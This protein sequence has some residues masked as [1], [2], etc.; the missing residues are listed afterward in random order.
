MSSSTSRPI[1][2]SRRRAMLAAGAG[3]AA[4]ALGPRRLLARQATPEA[5][6]STDGRITQERL[7]AVIAAVPEVVQDILD[8]TGVPGMAVAI[9]TA[10]G[11]P[12]AGGFGV[13][14]LVKPEPVNADT[15]FQL[16][17]LSKPVASTV[18]SALVGDGIVRW[19]S[20]MADLDPRF[21]L[22]DPWPTSQVT[23]ADLFS[24]RSGLP[25]HA[26][27]ALEDLGYERD[28]IIRRLRYLEPGYSF[29]DGYA[30]TNFGLSAAAYAAARA[31]D[32]DW[33]DISEARLYQPLGM[34]RTSSRFAD[35]MARDNRAIPHVRRDGAW[36]VTPEQRDPDPETPAGGVSSTANDLA[37]WLRMQINS[38]M[39]DGQQVI[40]AAA[41]GQTHVPHAV[42]H[43]P[44]D[45]FTQ[46]AG[47]YG[48]GWNVNYGENQPIGISHSGAFALGTGTAVYALPALGLGVLAL[49][50]GMPIGAPETVC[51]T[52]LHLAQTGERGPDLLPMIEAGFASL[53][54]PPYGTEVD[55]TAP[56]AETTPARDL[57][58]Y[59]GTYAN[60]FYGDL[61]IERAG[62]GL[63]M[64]VGPSQS[65]AMTHYDGDIWTFQPTGENAFGL[66]GMFFT[67]G[68]AGTATQLF[69]EYLEW[70]GD[71]EFAR[72]GG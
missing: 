51:L 25:D 16:A 61:V 13:L 33:S 4:A 63:S 24:H 19:D 6:S 62:D 60:D 1:A 56:L 43:A 65:F 26:G 14:E 8:R 45:P 11:V 49:T 70:G 72:T 31:A 58:A 17:S 34:N 7:D 15:V 35:Y 39:H 64:R 30:Y 44:T 27:D 53:L 41:L 20:R 46:R 50:N 47:F 54:A 71:G 2:L 12:F 52:L 9:V 59:A 23:L 28:D 48:L 68:P 36:M 69:A 66:S 21:A 5:A 32:G 57:D 42:P 38:G 55:Y 22:R 37:V 10:D 29:R 3:A 40:D 67:I 18:V